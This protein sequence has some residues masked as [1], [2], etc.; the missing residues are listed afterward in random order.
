MRTFKLMTLSMVM[1]TAA[2]HSGAA[3]NPVGTVVNSVRQEEPVQ[4]R[5]NPALEAEMEG[6]LAADPV[7]VAEKALVSG[8]K[9]L[10]VYYRRGQPVFPGV[11]T[12]PQDV[13]VKVAPGMGDIIY[14]RKHQLLR[15]AMLEFMERY[16][17]TILKSS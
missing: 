5:G 13:Q 1:V 8:D 14:G 11:A 15:R 9:G 16:N 7:T 17:R 4:V 6:I 12:P 10:W 2:C 3:G